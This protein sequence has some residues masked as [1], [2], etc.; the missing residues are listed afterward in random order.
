[1]VAR[2]ER[3]VLLCGLTE[4]RPSLDIVTEE[5]S[6]AQ[7][8]ELRKAMEESLRLS[9]FTNARRTDK[10]DTRGPS[11]SHNRKVVSQ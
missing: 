11:E 9:P 10:Y 6:G 3:H 1:M 4:R 2:R 5:V 7:R 8:L